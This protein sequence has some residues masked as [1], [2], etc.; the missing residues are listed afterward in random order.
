MTPRG[1][2]FLPP[3]IAVVLLLLLAA[4]ATLQYRWI[5]RVSDAERQRMHESL[6]SAGSRF[7][8]DVDRELTR[9]F[10]CFHPEPASD[11][12]GLERAVRQYDRW[13]AEAPWPDLIQGVFAARRNADGSMQLS[14]F[15]PEALRFEP[16]PWPAGFDAPRRLLAAALA[17]GQRRFP[18]A[19]I[20]V[21]C[22]TLT[23]AAGSA[24][25]YGSGRCTETTA[26][27]TST[28]C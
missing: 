25:A 9:A 4:L 13:R 12:E 8:E 20:V 3:A 26:S 2:R 10:L 28:C 15:R 23:G 14:R 18:L 5:G 22:A 6:L 11:E 24:T 1:A 27:P 17:G 21:A 19:V 16:V 7:T